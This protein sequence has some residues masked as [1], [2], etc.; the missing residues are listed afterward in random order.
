MNN[1]N[2]ESGPRVDSTL[3][4]GLL[5]LENLA[6]SRE[7]KGVSQLSRELELT[8]SNTFRLLQSLIALGYVRQMDDKNYTASLKMW[9]VGRKIIDQLNLREICANEMQFL[10][11][12]TGETVYLAVQEG[13]Q[14]VYVDKIESLK[15]IRSWNPI[16]GSAP[17]HC[18]GTGKAL[19]AANYEKMR[20]IVRGE[21]KRY[22]DKTITNIKALDDDVE[23]TRLKGYAFDCGEFRDQIYSFGAAIYLPSGEA[24]AALGISMPEMNMPADSQETL[25][26]I[27]AGAAARVSRKMLTH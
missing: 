21:L 16:G 5:I 20:D 12:E 3:S 17:L 26:N 25:G 9:Q 10:S 7:S 19:L 27:V 11:N 4:K 24:I 14:V 8:K 23:E 6:A 1:V 22:T 18:V 15:P 13:V 2:P